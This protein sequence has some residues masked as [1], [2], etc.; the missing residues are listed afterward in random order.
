VLVPG[1]G[2]FFRLIEQDD[3]SWSFFRGLSLQSR[4]TT[5]ED[6]KTR[7]FAM[8]EDFLPSTVFAHYRDGRIATIATFDEET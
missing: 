3:G 4:H 5:L 1:N 6:A 8:A 2:W 7:A